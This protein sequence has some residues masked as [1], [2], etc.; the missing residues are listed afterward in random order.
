MKSQPLYSASVVVVLMWM[1]S[2]PV[3]AATEAGRILFARGV[4]SIVDENE[5]ARQVRA[6]AVFNEG[7]RVVTGSN[8]IVQLRL[9]DGALTALRSNSEYHIQRQRFDEVAGIYE[10]AGRLVS[11]WMRSVTG[12]IGARSPGNVSQGTSVA[13]IGIRGTVYQIIHVPEEGLPE[14]PNLTPGSYIYLEEGQIEVTNAAGS[15]LVMPGQ[16][17]RVR[18]AND[19]P[20]LAPELA[21]MFSSESVTGGSSVGADDFE[22]RELEEEADGALETLTERVRENIRDRGPITPPVL[23]DPALPP[24]PGREPFETFSGGAAVYRVDSGEGL[25]NEGGKSN[26]FS[27]AD[28]TPEGFVRELSVINFSDEATLTGVGAAPSDFGG[29][30]WSDGTRIL[31]GYWENY[32]LDGPF[33]PDRDFHY[34]VSTDIVEFDYFDVNSGLALTAGPLG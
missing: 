21:D 28:I 7:D 23:R 24:E 6:G 2:L 22:I 33:T 11:G 27:T 25:W 15:R 9:T 3:Q 26:T 18:G 13:T 5:S 29:V 19:A 4:V 20:E 17:V 10:Q 14:F 8:S 31:W 12:T 16:V 30:T 34:I 32:D 1:L